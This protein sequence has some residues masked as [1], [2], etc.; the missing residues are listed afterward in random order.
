MKKSLT[1]IILALSLLT[2]FS[3]CGTKTAKAQGYD[4]VLAKLENGSGNVEDFD[5]NLE[6]EAKKMIKESDVEEIRSLDDYLIHYNIARLD[7]NAVMDKLDELNG[8]PASIDQKRKLSDDEKKFIVM[9]WGPQTVPGQ[10][11]KPVFYVSFNKPARAVTA[12]GSDKEISEILTV[13]PALKGKWYWNGTRQVCFEPETKVDPCQVYTINVKADLKDIDGI[14]LSGTTEFKTKADPVKVNSVNAG[15]SYD[16]PVYTSYYEYGVPIDIAGNLAVSVNSDITAAQFEKTIRITSNRKQYKYTVT[17]VERSYDKAAKKF[18]FKK[19]DRSRLFYVKVSER[20]YKDSDVS[21]ESYEGNRSV[22]K[23]SFRTLKPFKVNSMYFMP[24]EMCV[25]VYFSHPLKK[26]TVGLDSIKV[27]YQGR[28]SEI[29]I[30]KHQLNVSGSVLEIKDLPLA[31]NSKMTVSVNC[32]GYGDV[33]GQTASG[34]ISKT[35]TIP[36]PLSYLSMLTTGQKIMEA[37]FPHKFIIEHQNLEN[38]KYEVQALT[39]PYYSYN[40]EYNNRDL[41]ERT[42]SSIKT[43]NEPSDSVRYLEEINLDPYLNHGLGFV[44]VASQG[45]VKYWDSWGEVYKTWKNSVQ[46]AV[47]QVTDLGVTA[48]VGFNKAVVLVR[49]LKDNSP[50]AG[51]KVHIYENNYR[52]EENLDD[53]ESI[54][55][56]SGVTDKNGFAE[57]DIKGSNIRKLAAVDEDYLYV[58]VSKGNDKVTFHANNHDTWSSG[59]YQSYRTSSSR[60]EYYNFLFTDR[61]LYKPGETV[62]FRGIARYEDVM[63]SRFRRLNELE[64]PAY[65]KYTVKL[66]DTS[67]RDSKVIAETSGTFSRNGGY[68]GSFDLPNDLEPGQYVIEVSQGSKRIGAEYITVAYFERAKFQVNTTIPSIDYFAGDSLNAEI[69]ATYL[70]GGALA[71]GTYTAE[72]Y[73]SPRAFTPPGVNASGYK[74]GPSLDYSASSN[75]QETNGALS[76][77]GKAKVSVNTDKLV[78]GQAYRYTVE[79]TVTDVS[80]QRI[81]SSASA[82]VHP[83]KYYIGIQNTIGGGFVKSGEKTDIRY[84]LLN[85]KGEFAD[86][87]IGKEKL[88]YTLTRTYWTTVSENAV[89]GSV[90]TKWSEETETVASGTLNNA[91]KGT[92]TVTP[93]GAGWYTLTI[94]GKDNGGNLTKTSKE[95]FTT[96]SDYYWYSRDDNASIKLTPNQ[97]K[98]SPGETASILLESAL[99]AGDYLVTVERNDIY[100]T[101]VIHLDGPCTVLEVPVK[102]EYFPVAYVSVSSWSVRKGKPTHDYKEADYGKPKG[103]YGVTSLN[104]DLDVRRFKVEVTTDKKQYRPGEEVTIN[105]KAT[106][107]GKPVSGAELTAMVV[108]RAIVDLINYHVPD[109]MNSFYS[110]Y[111]YPLGVRGGDNRQYIMD[112]VT[113]KIKNLQGGD[114]ESSGDVKEQER[115]DFRPTALFK[116]EFT[117]DDNGC[118]SVK[119]KLPDSL[120]TFRITTFGVNETDFSLQEEEILVCNPINVQ[121][122]QPRRLRVRDTAECGVLV[123]NMDDKSHK[124]TVDVDV[125]APSKNYEEDEAKGLITKKGKAAIDGKSSK[126]VTVEPG[127]SVPVYFNVSALGVGNVELVYTMKSAIF[128]DKLASRILIE[129]TYVT[130]TVATLGTVKD[131]AREQIVIPS[132]VDDNYGSI[133]VNLDPTR[134]S[135]MSSSVGYVFNYPYGCLEQQSSRILPLLIFGEYIEE[136]GLKSEVADPEKTVKNWF[137]SVKDEQHATGGFPYWPG[138]AKDSTYVSL[139]FAYMWALAKERGYTDSEIGYDIDKLCSYLNSEIF[140]KSDADVSYNY[141]KAYACF[142]LGSVVKQ[143]SSSSLKAKVTAQ[144]DKLYTVA[145]SNDCNYSLATYAHIGLAYFNLGDKT[146]AKKMLDKLMTFVVPSNRTVSIS[147]SY[148]GYWGTLYDSNSESKALIMQ[149]LVSMRPSDENVNKILYTLLQEQ[150]RGYWQS[151]ATTARVFESIHTLIK[152]R[153]LQNLDFKGTATLS[154]GKKTVELIKGAFKGLGAKPVESIEYFDGK[155]INDL[156]RN[157]KL[158]LDFEKEG[159]GDMY[160][161]VEMKYA[162]P[163]ELQI[164]RDAGFEVLYSIYDAKTG[165]EIK[166]TSESTK[167]M[168]LETGKTYKIKVKISTNRSREYVATRIAIPSGCEIVDSSLATGGSQAEKPASRDDDYDDWWQWYYGSTQ[169]Y[170]D[171]EAQYM[172]EYLWNGSANYELT[173]RASRRGVYPCPPVMTECMYEPEVFGRAN[174]YLFVI[175]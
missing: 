142:I 100:S 167:V 28:D 112:P 133:K 162:L 160:Y 124:V 125:R 166:T 92:L 25:R 159:K 15:V 109:P 47:I 1:G 174:G 102:E 4:A 43:L 32:D 30:G 36:G 138:G 140:T 97:E 175:K 107:N 57:I 136:L 56:A 13:T 152:A 110:R 120:T 87:E 84:V 31:Y 12:L 132:W 93:K 7:L 11:S 82:V 123:T 169:K 113:Y 158:N 75:N 16:N 81:F 78:P 131:K 154:D 58:Y 48:R 40:Y 20:F 5:V 14:K 128:N 3:G 146:R 6:A 108:D 104:V 24:G 118:A 22:S 46:E 168:I 21:V 170:Y 99:E 45:Y 55:L 105:F 155:K 19:T 103:Y 51:A 61:G 53:I 63:V 10:L 83:A 54:S 38:G 77:E 60:K 106:K 50:V 148:V 98:Y 52:H 18:V 116:P 150:K 64:I 49:S 139:R 172:T 129:K 164:A 67:W 153:D 95:F 8:N 68:W 161:T 62:N 37:Q 9:N 91:S 76:S 94:T 115:K 144:L 156:R 71:G 66:S 42:G 165:E 29:G 137:S 130:E 90:Y 122:I 34:G 85:T 171:N 2:A 149:L 121:Q 163:D 135:L 173:I 151:T 73:S 101:Q 117:T 134:L 157:T 80:N 145:T 141:Y 86:K 41:F 147:E 127:K 59:V 44:R 119:F 143:N 89:D 96:G 65:E 27:E 126:T 70:A 39:D 23:R 79:T 26:E 17:P 111:N 114:M 69:K 72:W 33:F 74:F 35:F 88:E